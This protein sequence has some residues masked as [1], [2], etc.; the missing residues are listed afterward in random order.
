MPQN[1]VNNTQA[2]FE[3]KKQFSQ[4]A[5]SEYEELAAA[6]AAGVFAGRS[7]EHRRC[8]IGRSKLVAYIKWLG[9]VTGQ[10]D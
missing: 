4:S 7:Y 2:S 5:A 10:I 1:A 6:L 9:K 3:M 8:V